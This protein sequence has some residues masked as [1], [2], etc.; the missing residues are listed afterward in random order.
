M[1]ITCT[2]DDSLQSSN[3]KHS[4]PGICTHYIT[5]AAQAASVT[6]HGG[7]SRWA[8]HT[9]MLL[10]ISAT[11]AILVYVVVKHP[12]FMLEQLPAI[13]LHCSWSYIGG[14]LL[15][16]FSF[17]CS[18][19]CILKF[20]TNTDANQINVVSP[21]DCFK[22]RKIKVVLFRTQISNKLFH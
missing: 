1:P 4:F 16:C 12:G 21:C 14:S 22:K 8:W 5:K 9:C 3:E 11:M 18:F 15:S 7:N 17:L 6:S 20:R 10:R 19:L 13:H 2:T